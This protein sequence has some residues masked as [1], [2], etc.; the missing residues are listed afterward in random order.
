[1]TTIAFARAYR[2]LLSTA[3]ALVTGAAH[4]QVATDGTLGA[5]TRL[6]GPDFQIGAGLGRTAGNNL[7]QSFSELSLARGQSATFLG[8]SS[9]LN[10]IARV[11]GGSASSIDGT[12]RTSAMPNASFW[13]INPAGVMFGPNAA[14]DVAGSVY[15]GTADYLVLGIGAGSGRFDADPARSSTLVAAPP[16]AFGFLANAPA[17]IVVDGARLAVRAGGEIALVGG[18]VRLRESSLVAPAGRVQVGAVASA[19]EASVGSNG[20]LDYAGFARLGDVTLSRSGANVSA[21]RPNIN[22][23]SAGAAGSG[24]VYL[25]GGRFFSDSGGIGADN[26]ASEAGGTID[27]AFRE[28]IRLSGATLISSNALR[29]GAAGGISLQAPDIAADGSS[30]LRSDSRAAGAAGDIEVRGGT[31]RFGGFSRLASN[32]LG[33]GD[34]GTIRVE[35]TGD[36]AF[37]D[38]A[39]IRVETDFGGRAGDI[40]VSGGNVSVSGNG[41]FQASTLVGSSGD[42]GTISISARNAFSLTGTGQ[43]APRD[44]ALIATSAYGSGDGGDVR[45]EAPAILVGGRAAIESSANGPGDAGGIAISGDDV[46]VTGGSAIDS[47][48]ADAG[49]GGPITV[50]AQDFRLDSGSRLSAEALGAGLAGDIL[51]RSARVSLSDARISTA[52]LVSDGGNIA[53]LPSELLFLDAAQVETSVRS[54]VGNGGNIAI[55]E[56]GAPPLF[57]IARDSRVQANA[58]GGNGGNVD[59]TARFIVLSSTSVVEASSALGI[60]G[61][62]TLSTPEVDVSA[63]VPQTPPPLRPPAIDVTACRSPGRGDS[64]LEV[65]PS[66]RATFAQPCS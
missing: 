46:V 26:R 44:S 31:V 22:V 30:E 42:G 29:G 59:L 64:R 12:I 11:T 5:A 48:S 6:Q 24:S 53:I 39:S 57:L 65:A 28:S 36:V 50:T 17:G 8:P 38:D 18:S 10:V 32:A 20:V 35:A 19:G 21:A 51:V 60:D 2:G 34:G 40:V 14:L 23:D 15:I 55:G 54:G 56:P 52:A 63:L 4:A 41:T 58:F 33:A 61:V 1:M 49:N 9:I 62:I 7:F 16:S 27:L 25:R 37:A 45:I 66:W 43:G 3:L 47:R 13:L